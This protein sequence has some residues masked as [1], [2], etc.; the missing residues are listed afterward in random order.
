MN[1]SDSRPIALVTGGCAGLGLVITRTLISHGYQVIALDRN[2]SQMRQ[3][4]AE[5]GDRVTVRKCD[6]TV[7]AEV[8]AVFGDLDRLDVLVNCVGVSDRGLLEKLSLE[9]LDQL[10][11]L[12][13]HCTLLCSQQAL[14][15]LKQSGGVIVN[16]G[17]LAAKV[18]A[19]Y[20]GAYAICKH[21]VAALTQ[22]LRLELKP[23]G[24]HVGL[25]SPGPI[26]RED[27]GQRYQEIIGD[28]LPDQAAKPGGGTKVKGLPPQRVA[29]AVVRCIDKRLPDIVLPGYLRL[30]ISFGHA[31]PRLGDWLL[32]KFTS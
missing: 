28:D 8:A 16:I 22:Q 25:V 15:L 1:D 20:I 32:L 31:F 12:N 2:E 26:R 5:L 18:G 27:A 3:V 17:S 23:S 6:V 4:V 29:D 7:E 30:L 11:P 9:R 13:V 24:V 14:P 19:R 21:G 10:L